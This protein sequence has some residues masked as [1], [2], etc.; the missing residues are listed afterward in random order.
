MN[1]GIIAESILPNFA[2]YSENKTYTVGDIR[3]D[4][5]NVY[6]VEDSYMV[7]NLLYTKDGKTEE[8]AYKHYVFTLGEVKRLLKLYGLH[9]IAA[10]S[11][12]S[13]SAYKLGDQQVYIVAQKG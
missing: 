4:V 8:H 9:T 3:M 12:T 11:S 13:K 6:H 10:Y 7:S 2:H 5:T 1:S